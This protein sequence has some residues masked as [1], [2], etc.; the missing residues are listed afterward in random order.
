[1]ADKYQ[2]N[3]ILQWFEQEA[4]VERINYATQSKSESLLLAYPKLLLSLAIQFGLME[5]AKIALKELAGC[6]YKYLIAKPDSI[7]L[8]LFI[9]IGKIRDERIRRFQREID[10]LVQRH[11]LYTE[12]DQDFDDS[13]IEVCIGC[14]ANRA[15]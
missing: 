5:T 12:Y 13:E 4:L 15:R 6:D 14:A 7:S 9:K 1:M 10:L 11:G 8:A 2:T 3:S